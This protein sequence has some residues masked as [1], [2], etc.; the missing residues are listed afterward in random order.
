MTT[1]AIVPIKPLNR[2]KSRLSPVLTGEQRQALSQKMLEMT[3]TTLKQVKAISGVLAVS[4]DSKALTLA[5]RFDVQTVQ[6][7]GAP[8]LNDALTRATQA[9]SSWNATSVLIL[10]SDIPL[11]TVQDIEGI[12]SLATHADEIVVIATDRR[13]EGTNALL[14][15]PPGL[16]PYQYGTGSFRRH[17]E[18]AQKA[19]AAVEV[20]RSPTMALDVDMPEDLALYREIASQ[21]KL[22]ELAWLGSL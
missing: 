7:S 4:R 21:Q 16:I 2:S 11:M 10:A 12:L 19:G 3:L 1:W 6:E 9:V 17:V 14:V 20:Y 13:E 18:E 22:S 5:R 8:E 15:S